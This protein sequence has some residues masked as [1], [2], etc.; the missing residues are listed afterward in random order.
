MWL[1][2]LRYKCTGWYYDLGKTGRNLL[3]WIGA[4]ILVGVAYFAFN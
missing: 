3:W 2:N 4:L 1:K